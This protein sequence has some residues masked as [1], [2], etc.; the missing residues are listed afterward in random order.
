MLASI[1]GIQTLR[2]NLKFTE[3]IKGQMKKSESSIKLQRSPRKL[4]MHLKGPE[5]LWIEGSNNGDALV[6]P[7]AFP[8]FNLNLD[9]NGSLLR[10]DQ[11]HTINEVGF[12]Y[13]AEILSYE[14]K[15]EASH[16]DK[17]F[18]YTGLGTMAG[19]ECY[20][21]TISDP[22]FSF[23]DYVVKKNE[24]I[25]TVAKKLRLSEYMILENNKGIKDYYSV[26]EG[27][28]IKVPTSYAKFTVLY[29][30]KQNMLPIGNT[31]TD[32][33]GIFEA[34]EY[35]NLQLNSKIAPEEFTKEYKDYKF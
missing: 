15:K 10:T 18:T 23:I 35:H 9:P 25:I 5:L 2:Y 19:R 20:K 13:M 24:T 22:A 29:I 1:N 12:E 4:Y 8:Y 31:V 14:I 6:N 32:D 34:Y 30:D 33:K 28:T 27:M 7:N 16:F 26:K 3:R 21:V 17:T 11:H